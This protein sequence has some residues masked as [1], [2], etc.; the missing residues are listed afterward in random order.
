MEDILMAT[1]VFPDAD[2]LD[3]IQS[4]VDEQDELLERI[5][6][7]EASAQ[8]RTRLSSVATELSQEWDLVRQRRALRRSGR[9]PH[10]AQLRDAGVVTHYQQ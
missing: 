6:R 10:Q 5:S 7:G 9:D 8:E 2:L 3:E 1:G 4:L